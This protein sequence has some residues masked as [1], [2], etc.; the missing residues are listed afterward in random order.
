M[1]KNNVFLFILQLKFFLKKQK[2]SNTEI[3]R[4]TDYSKQYFKFEII[5]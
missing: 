2:C 4:F 3:V 1:I 5:K